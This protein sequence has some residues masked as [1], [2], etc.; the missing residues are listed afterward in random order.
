MWQ[1]SGSNNL[2][3]G[4]LFY[5]TASQSKVLMVPWAFASETKNG[6]VVKHY[7]IEYVV[8]HVECIHMVDSR[9]S[10]PGK[11]GPETKYML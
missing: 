2:K 9:H 7:G 10:K 1:N 4:N 3:K 5:L 8:D 11:E 6:C